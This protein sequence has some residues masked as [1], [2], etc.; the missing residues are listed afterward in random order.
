MMVIHA[1]RID[2]RVQR[3]RDAAIDANGRIE[4]AIQIAERNRTLRH[5]VDQKTE[6][7]SFQIQQNANRAARRDATLDA[8]LVH[9]I[10]LKPRSLPIDVHGETFVVFA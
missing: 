8:S 7:V 1:R 6:R 5:F 4:N 10:V 3:Q 2:G 9:R